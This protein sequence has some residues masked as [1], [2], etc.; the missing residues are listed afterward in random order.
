MFCGLLFEVG[1]LL[2][3]ELGCIMGLGTLLLYI[4]K[5]SFEIGVQLLDE[6]LEVGNLVLNVH[7]PVDF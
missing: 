4:G 5:V 2:G 1:L 7:W 3:V 6:C